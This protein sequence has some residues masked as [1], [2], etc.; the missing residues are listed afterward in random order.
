MAPKRISTS[1]APTM[2]QAAIKKLV[3]D[4]VAA[5]LEAQAA[6]MA[7][8]D[9]T[10]R[11]TRQ[12]GTPVARKCRYKEFMSCQSFNFK[13]TE[14]AGMTSRLTLEDSR[15]AI[16]CPSM[17]PNSE[18]I[19]D[20]F[21]EE[22]YLRSIEGNVNTQSRPS[23]FESSYYHNL[24]VN[25]LG[26]LKAF[27]SVKNATCIT[28]DLALSSVRLATSIMLELSVTRKSSTSPSTVKLCSY[29]GIEVNPT[30]PHI[31]INSERYILQGIS[32]FQSQLME[33]KSNEKR[34]EDIP[35]VW[36]FLE[37]FPENLPGLPPVRQVEFQIDLMLGS[38]LVARAPYRLAP[39]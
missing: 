30:K 26:I 37:V 34:L 36:E 21:L 18:N 17:V 13:G 24:E 29:E 4:S 2:T 12:S 23:N 20:V 3:A 8:T 9:N 19:M 33:K 22:L 28:Q 39:S 16:R 25:G 31:L 7:N 10:N 6:T 1:A 14:G 38:A 11:N 32:S 15:S 5:A 27:P 35:V